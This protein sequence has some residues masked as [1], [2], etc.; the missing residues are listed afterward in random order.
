[1]AQKGELKK[2]QEASKAF[3]DIVD[4]ITTYDI[5]QIKLFF[6]NL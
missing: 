4:A 6:S 5:G 1:M 3:K 2:Y